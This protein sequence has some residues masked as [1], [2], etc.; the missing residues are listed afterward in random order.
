MNPTTHI[1]EGRTNLSAGLLI[2]ALLT[3]T[4]GLSACNATPQAPAREMQAA[5]SAISAAE[6][7]GIADYAS[8]EL[9]VAREKLAA[10]KTAISVEKMEL[11]SRLAEE[12]RVNAELAAA[13]FE[14]LKAKAINV[15]M[16]K[17]T[18][19]MNQE[20]QRNSGDTQ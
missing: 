17:G 13:R 7:G 5:E 18:D 1:S 16:M 19:M 9:G 3:V 2:T 10:A 8:P 4:L 15:E 20:M 12:S 6:R 14:A 11:A